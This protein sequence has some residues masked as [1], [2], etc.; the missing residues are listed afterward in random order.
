MHIP[1]SLLQLFFFFYSILNISVVGGW[2]ISNPDAVCAAGTSNYPYTG[3]FS[4]PAPHSHHGCEH[5]SALR[6]HRAVPYPTSYMQKNN[7]PGKFLSCFP[8][9]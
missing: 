6:G 4:L 1:I 3:S 5:Y 9:N 8:F 2:L 7:Y